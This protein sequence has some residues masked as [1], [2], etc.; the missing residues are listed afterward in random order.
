M[1]VSFCSG[2]LKHPNGL[3]I[4]CMPKEMLQHCEQQKSGTS[5][6]FFLQARSSQATRAAWPSL[7]ICHEQLP[8]ITDLKSLSTNRLEHVLTANNSKAKTTHDCRLWLVYYLTVLLAM[9]LAICMHVLKHPNGTCMS[10]MPKE[11]LQHCGLQ[12]SGTRGCPFHKMQITT[13]Y[14]GS[15]AF[16]E[17]LPRTATTYHRLEIPE[18]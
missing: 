5:R 14:K 12:T 2:V 16:T 9:L 7:K 1:P 10:C 3:C 15:T 13:S 4:S 8:H 11:V 17:D 18:Q 6:R